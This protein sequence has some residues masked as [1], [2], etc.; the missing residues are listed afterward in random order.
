MEMMVLACRNHPDVVE[1]LHYC[2]RCGQS[3]CRDCLVNIRGNSFCASCKAE[4]VLDLASGV[5]Q[6]SLELASVGRR[7]AAIFLDGLVLSIPFLILMFT[8]IFAS[9]N[10]KNSAPPEGMMVVWVVMIFAYPVYEALMLAS[11]GQT[12]G[13]IAM[14]VKVVRPD[15]GDITTGQAWGRAFMRTILAS[16][17]SLFNYIPAFFTKERTCLHDLVANTRVVNWS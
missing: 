3:Y 5:D 15:G 2:S 13:K 12:L 14:K 6:S 16:C 11:R 9:V 7:L 8:F 1:G 4:Q 17:L 10:N